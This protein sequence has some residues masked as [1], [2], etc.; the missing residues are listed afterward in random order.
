M[1]WEPKASL[2]RSARKD[3]KKVVFEAHKE[4]RYPF[5][6]I[7]VKKLQRAA[8]IVTVPGMLWTTVKS[9]KLNCFSHGKLMIGCHNERGIEISMSVFG[10]SFNE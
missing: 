8:I 3:E 6:Y 5:Q 2:A 9:W 10:G 7:A 1:C 4:Y